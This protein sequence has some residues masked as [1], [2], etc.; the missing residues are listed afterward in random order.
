MKKT[1]KW[2][3][4]P[5]LI[6]LAALS[7]GL[8]IF[9]LV[10]FFV[11]KSAGEAVLGV[12]WEVLPALIVLLVCV[13]VLLYLYL[14]LKKSAEK[15]GASVGEA[16][17]RIINGESPV[18]VTAVGSLG[19]LADGLFRE[20]EKTAAAFTKARSEADAKATEREQL[21]A[22]LKIC[23]MQTPEAVEFDGLRYGVC[24][25]THY[26]SEVG[27]NFAEAFPL[28]GRRVFVAV[29]DVWGS[30]LGA[31]LFSA[32]VKMLL[33]ENILSGRDTAE[34]LSVVNS[35]L[36]RE[37]AEA[38]IVTLFCGIFH[39]DSGA[40]RCANAGHYP[41]LLTGDAAGYLPV[42]PGTPLGIFADAQY[43]EEVFALLP[44]QGLFLYT[45]A[46]VN[47]SDG[48]ERFGYDR[49]AAVLKALCGS[50][51]GADAVTE[52]MAAALA[53]FCGE[54]PD[55]SELMLVFPGGTQR[56]FRAKLPEAEGMRG[57]L[58]EWL[59]SDPRKSNILS[60]CTEIF[61]GIV[62]NAGAR[63]VR[64]GC[65][66]GDGFIAVR[67]TED[68]EPFNPLQAEQGSEHGLGADLHRLGG[69]IFYR[70]KQDLCVLTVRFPSGGAA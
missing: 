28:D 8:L 23:R 52:G 17:Q 59:G 37:N 16:T 58:S 55:F 30:G 40:L 14:R 34:T 67:F 63:A 50:A 6:L 49:L 48:K 44:E 33:R 51:L 2:L 24:G 70:T 60:V 61:K 42:Q 41:P 39:C 29:G 47:S 46:A 56:L 65:E 64:V 20:E 3:F 31:A 25:R 15:L 12:L 9:A 45:D 13:A 36:C 4:I 22:A 57:F 53:E 11:L 38:Y 1:E 32:R 26:S 54:M 5:A 69:E 35:T 62:E 27:A 66:R 43:A 7:L 21:A 18:S 68:G 10:R 19:T